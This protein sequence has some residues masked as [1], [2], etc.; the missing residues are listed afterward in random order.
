MPTNRKA[1]PV[2]TKRAQCQ[3]LPTRRPGPALTSGL[4]HAER[5]QGRGRG[6]LGVARR[7]LPGAHGL[8]HLKDGEGRHVQLQQVQQDPGENTRGG[9]EPSSPRPAALGDPRLPRA[10]T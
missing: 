2:G 3:G 1:W 6:V 5:G 8:E 10:L 9:S 7:P 4:R